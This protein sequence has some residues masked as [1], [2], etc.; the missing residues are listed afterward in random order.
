VLGVTENPGQAADSS[1]APSATA[2][3]Q[4]Y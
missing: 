2:T 3:S 1:T 4:T